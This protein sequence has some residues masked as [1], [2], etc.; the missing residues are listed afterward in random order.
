MEHP[1]A[2][3]VRAGQFDDA[4]Q[5]ID[6]NRRCPLQRKATVDLDELGHE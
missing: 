4:V 6:A 5:S 1:A 2:F 3:R